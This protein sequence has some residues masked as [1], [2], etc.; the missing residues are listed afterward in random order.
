M[1]INAS[2]NIVEFPREKKDNP[3]QNREEFMDQI[4][5]L[6]MGYAQELADVLTGVVL[7]ELSRMTSIVTSIEDDDPLIELLNGTIQALYLRTAGI[8]H[9]YESLAHALAEQDNEEL[10][11]ESNE[12]EED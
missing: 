7:G 12:S 5:S 11:E 8:E 3:P 2:N 1:S 4:V 10:S 6:R 9:P